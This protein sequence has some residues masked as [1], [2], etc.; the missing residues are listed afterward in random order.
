MVMMA[1]RPKRRGFKSRRSDKRWWSGVTAM[2]M[3]NRAQRGNCSLTECD[4]DEST[5][6]E[7]IRGRRNGRRERGIWVGATMNSMRT[8]R[9]GRR[10]DRLSV[11]HPR[12]PDSGLGIPP[13]ALK[14][15]E[16]RQSIHSYDRRKWPVIW[17]M[18]CDMYRR[19]KP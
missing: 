1:R 16:T 6:Q 2:T 18:N 5:D 4:V 12:G 9:F 14:V 15:Q 8:S 19:V 7:P 3:R 10:L 11:R 17:S 13:P